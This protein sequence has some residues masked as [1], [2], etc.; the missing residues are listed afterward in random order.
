MIEKNGVPSKELIESCFPD[1]IVL[2]KPKA[3]IECYKE[4]PC[5][6]CSTSCPFDAIFIPEDINVRPLI[7]YDKCTGCGICVYNCPGLAITVRMLKGD[8]V[9]MK[10][11]YEFL[12][13]P[14]KGEKMNVM[15]RSG[16]IITQGEVTK[17][18]ITERHNKTALVHLEVEREFLYDAMTV[19]VKHGR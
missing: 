15:N 1:Q 19:E 17:V 12:P 7:D 11:P 2:E 3:I 14:E 4:I 8:K 10:I 18:H 6:P 5:N 9:E 16:D 13:Y